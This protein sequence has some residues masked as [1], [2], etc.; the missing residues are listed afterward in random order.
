VKLG[1]VATRDL[2]MLATAPA[3]HRLEELP[4]TCS[5]IASLVIGDRKKERKGRALILEAGGW[6]D[7]TH[8]D[9]EAAERIIKREFQ[10]HREAKER[11]DVRLLHE[12]KR[13]GRVNDLIEY[14]E[15]RELARGI[16][17]ARSAPER[18]PVAGSLLRWEELQ[19]LPPMAWLVDGVLP[20]RALAFLVG[21]SGV[22]KSSMA[23]SMG[24]AMAT[25][26]DWLGKATV[27]GRV[28]L[29]A[30]EGGAGVPKRLDAEWAAW[31]GERPDIEVRFGPLDLSD[32]ATIAELEAIV[33][34][35][36]P[37]LIV[38]DTLNRHAGDSDENAARD[39]AR[40]VRNVERIAAAATCATSV[41]VHHHGK[42]G[43]I[44]G[45]SAL[46]ASAD[47]VLELTGEP[48][49]LVLK[50]VKMKDF[51]SGRIGEFRLAKSPKHDSI[52]VEGIAP[53]SAALGG[54]RA[55]RS[56]EALELFAKAFGETGAT[57]SQAKEH[58]M[59]LM[60]VQRSAADNYIGDLL[61]RGRLR[62]QTRASGSAFLTLAPPLTSFEN[63]DKE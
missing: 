39:M 60:G 18:P 48:G 49:G 35:R 34:E 45:S 31:G 43:D 5:S 3:E 15:D 62:A 42:G 22:G 14:Y 41:V 37:V 29:F 25:G 11:A 7:D 50:A 27:P 61:S 21:P 47:V 4:F 17:A 36:D 16:V 54:A 55:G 9:R 2:K 57:R 51:E 46:Y 8:P 40:V 44:R 19:A 24:M 58:L 23:L 53:G 10:R 1:P 56:E 33:A 59:E 38:W 32:E 6:L 13:E 20:E 12:A 26:R 52:H 63:T 30:G 28:L